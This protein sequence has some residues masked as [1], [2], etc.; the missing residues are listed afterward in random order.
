MDPL[1][2]VSVTRVNSHRWIFG[3]SII[4]ER[5][6]DPKLKPTNAIV[7]WQDGSSTLYLRENTESLALIGDSE[8]ILLGLR[9]LIGLL[10]IMRSVKTKAG[11]KG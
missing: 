3:S 5:V 10:E 7:H 2:G 8:S 9:L 1:I 6:E 11:V 4:C